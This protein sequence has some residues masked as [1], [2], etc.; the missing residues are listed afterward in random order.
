MRKR[1]VMVAIVAVL[2]LAPSLSA[3]SDKKKNEEKSAPAAAPQTTSNAAAANPGYVIGPEDVL[4]INIWKEPEMSGD[5]PVRPD[6]KISLT[7]LGDVQ[8]AG[9]TPTQ[10]T[11]QITDL[12]KKYLDDPRV[13]VT[14]G[15]VNSRRVFILGQV[16]RPGAFPLLPDMTVLQALSTAGGLSLYAAADKIYVLR[17]E[18]G[19][20]VKLAFQYKQVI[21]GNKPEQ[22]IVLKSGDTIVVP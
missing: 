9:L 18:N 12:L 21:K 2:V 11:T 13:T 3:S 20:Q 14:V 6:G 4:K 5:V 19:N 16:G 15:A 22:N 8:A 1:T 7:L 10:L 17:I